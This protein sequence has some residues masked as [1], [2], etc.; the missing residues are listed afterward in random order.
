MASPHAG[1]PGRDHGHVLPISE[2]ARANRQ[3]PVLLLQGPVGPFFQHLAHALRAMGHPVDRVRFNAGDRLNDTADDAAADLPPYRKLNYQEGREAFVPWLRGLCWRNHYEAIV[4]FGDQ[5]PPHSMAREVAAEFGI[6]VICLEEGYVRGGFVT[7]ERGGNNARSVHAGRLP[8][9]AFDEAPPEPVAAHG[10]SWMLWWAFLS[11]TWRNVRSSAIEREFN[12]KKRPTVSEGFHWTRNAWRRYTGYGM[13]VREARAL[14]EFDLV[15]LQ[16]TDDAQLGEAADGWSNARLIGT[17][18]ESFAR[19]APKERHLVFKLHPMERGH[20]RDASVIAS[21]AR[22]WGVGRR[23]HCVASGSLAALTA[24]A[25]GMITINSTSGFTA[26]EFGMSLLVLGRAVYR[27]PALA[28]CGGTVESINRFWLNDQR[29]DPA[30]AER[31]VCWLKHS[32]LVPGDYYDPAVAEATARAVAERA[33]ALATNRFRIPMPEVAI[34]S[35]Q[36]RA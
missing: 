33:I 17:A 31:F 24:K 5:R 36:A 3:R 26:L 27:H 14:P 11:F 23:V 12:H 1:E 8:P 32:A 21:L 22:R 2:A 16:V 13:D 34:E 9:E 7:V 10:F 19:H 25:R 4:L 18:I 15:P 28:Q 30:L 20:T 35:A 6:P 29:A